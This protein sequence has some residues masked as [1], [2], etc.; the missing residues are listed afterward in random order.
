MAK[1]A[2]D[3]AADAQGRIFILDPLAGEIR[4]MTRK[5]GTTAA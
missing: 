2:L 3:A 5:R 1:A 4:V